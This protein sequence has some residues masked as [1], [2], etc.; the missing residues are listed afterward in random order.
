MSTQETYCRQLT[1]QALQEMGLTPGDAGEFMRQA[2]KNSG[3]MAGGESKIGR[4]AMEQ[5]R[6]DADDSFV[7]QQRE[8]EERFEEQKLQEA[9]AAENRPAEDQQNARIMGMPMQMTGLLFG[10]GLSE[11]AIEATGAILSP[12]LDK[13][14][15]QMM[16]ISS[17]GD[18]GILD[19]ARSDQGLH[20][21]GPQDM[22]VTGPG[23]TAPFTPGQTP[24]LQPDAQ[25]GG[26][27]TMGAKQNMAAIPG[28]SG[29]SFGPGST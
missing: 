22:L 20:N 24:A 25:P 21:T 1:W 18:G 16:V 23:Q 29:P 15:D 11:T 27:G 5:G 4:S 3:M 8:N 10:L 14:D 28:L 9:K 6:E 13:I 19:Q 12:G 7:K 17:R 2:V 26:M